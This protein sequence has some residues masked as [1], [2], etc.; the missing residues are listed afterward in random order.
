MD[1]SDP[2]TRRAELELA[3]ME[4]HPLYNRLGMSSGVRLNPIFEDEN[5]YQM[6]ARLL[7]LQGNGA[8]LPP[9]RRSIETYADSHFEYQA[10]SRLPIEGFVAERNARGGFS[11]PSELLIQ[12][13]NTFDTILNVSVAPVVELAGVRLS[14]MPGLQYTIRRDAEAPGP[15]NQNLFRQ[16]LYV[17]TSSIANWLAASGSLI[18]EAGPFSEMKLHSRDT[19]A[20]IDFRVGRPWGKTALLTGYS[21][22]DLLFG[23]IDREYY[24]TV[25]YGGVERAFGP[26]FHAS[27][28]AEFLRA[29]RVEGTRFV[30][31]QTLRP[32]FALDAEINPHWK[33]SASGYWS[34]GRSFHAY[35]SVSTNFV[36]T[37]TRDRSWGRSMAAETAST[38][39]PMR[40]SFGL[41]QQTFYDF[42]GQQHTQIVPVA[43]ITF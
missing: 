24:Q 27:A 34:S 16:Y 33:V 8:L 35:D 29:W 41:G 23:P 32:R 6:D 1:P 40:I 2:D 42:P 25:T 30:I 38:T 36:A 9:P 26:H 12:N 5:I 43:Q 3:E 20:T 4:G 19:A 28:V 21:A 11:F 10:S 22:R 37:Y 17:S 18:R 39:Y 14:I 13:R 15:M 7:G 31:A